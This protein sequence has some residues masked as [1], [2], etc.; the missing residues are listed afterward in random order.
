MTRTQRLWL[1]VGPAAL[2]A[3]WPSLWVAATSN[4]MSPQALIARARG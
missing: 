4:H 1:T 3:G 2:V